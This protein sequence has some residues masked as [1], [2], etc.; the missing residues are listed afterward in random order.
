MAA[1]VS[2]NLLHFA[3]Y[4]QDHLQRVDLCVLELCNSI[5]DLLRLLLGAVDL[6]LDALLELGQLVQHTHSALLR[7]LVEIVLHTFLLRLY[8]LHL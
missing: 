8:T 2:L 1:H 4:G 7:L 5:V 3:L 6:F